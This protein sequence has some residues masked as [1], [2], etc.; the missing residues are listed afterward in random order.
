MRRECPQSRCSE[1]EELILA[2]CAQV[3]HAGVDAAATFRNVH[4]RQPG[5]TH[6]LLFI[7]RTAEDRVRVRV[8]EAWREQV[9]ATVDDLRVA[10]F[11]AESCLVAN[12]CDLL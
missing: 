5:S 7:A 9:I 11:G 2:P 3:S 4:V 1:V 12:G 8:N 6:L 10:V